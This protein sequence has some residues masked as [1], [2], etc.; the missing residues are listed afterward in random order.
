[1]RARTRNTTEEIAL[2]QKGKV[3]CNKGYST[4]SGCMANGGKV[5]NDLLKF[6]GVKGAA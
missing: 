1:M 2:P 4:H 3:C 6:G 5:L